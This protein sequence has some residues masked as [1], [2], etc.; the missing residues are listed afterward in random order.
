MVIRAISASESRYFQNCTFRIVPL[1]ALGIV[2]AF[3][4]HISVNEFVPS[5]AQ[6]VFTPLRPTVIVPSLNPYATLFVAFG[7]NTFEV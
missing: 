6:L 5:N 3:P 1:S 4:R 2:V 7:R